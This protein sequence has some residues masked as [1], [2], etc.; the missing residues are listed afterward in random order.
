MTAPKYQGVFCTF[1][2]EQMLKL[3]A[4]K[5]EQ[6][7]KVAAAQKGGELEE[8]GLT[9]PYYGCTGGGYSYILTPTSLGMCVQVR[10]GITGEEI[11]LTDSEDW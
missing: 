6:D 9:P 5:D 2:D 11:D 10:N 8:M 3:R 1:T 4:W 7:A